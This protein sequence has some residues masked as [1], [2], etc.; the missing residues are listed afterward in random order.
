MAATKVEED[1]AKIE[2]L[3]VH[4]YLRDV[5][6][7]ETDYDNIITIII[8]Y[9][10]QGFAKYYDEEINK[11]YKE[12]MKFGDILKRK[13]PSP[14]F[15]KISDFM[16]LDMNNELQTVGEESYDIQGGGREIDIEIPLSIC[17]HLSNA[18]S[19]YSKFQK[20][21]FFQPIKYGD[22]ETGRDYIEF[23]FNIKYDDDWIIKHL[24]CILRKQYPRILVIFNNTKFERLFVRFGDRYYKNYNLINPII[25]HK[26]IDQFGEIRRDKNNLVKIRVKWDATKDYLSIYE[27]LPK[28][29]SFDEI[30]DANYR[31]LDYIG[32]K[33]EKDTMMGEIQKLYQSDM[34]CRD[35][36]NINVIDVSEADVLKM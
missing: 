9:Y 17:K 21:T 7:D 36:I 6:N 28:L 11:D 18:V 23:M 32:P 16:V 19:F 25:T 12:K 3:R 5:L 10:R 29:W 31:V 26:D 34:K 4:G 27:P 8:E 1:Y 2:E 20:I 13:S 14:N 22:L 35:D 33:K 15:W 30:G 24:N